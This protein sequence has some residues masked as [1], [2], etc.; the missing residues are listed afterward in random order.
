[1]NQGQAPMTYRQFHLVLS[2]MDPP[3]QPAGTITADFLERH[4]PKAVASDD[5][6]H[7]EKYGI[8]TLEELG[9]NIINV[10]IIDM[11]SI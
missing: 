2:R 6:D 11:L 3:S 5:E 10:A 8:P 9:N 7:D 1:M 4:C